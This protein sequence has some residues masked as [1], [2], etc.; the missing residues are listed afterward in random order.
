VSHT[1]PW[2]HDG[3][4]AELEDAV[5]YM[6]EHHQQRMGTPGSPTAAQV[7]DLVAYLEAL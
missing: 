7:A 5:T 4:Y 2:F 3:R 6:W 1:G